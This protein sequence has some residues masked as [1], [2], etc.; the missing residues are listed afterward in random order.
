MGCRALQ[1]ALHGWEVLGGGE[2]S[3]P[4]ELDYT[5]RSHL[6]HFWAAEQLDNRDNGTLKTG[7]HG[8]ARGVA[9]AA[10]DMSSTSMVRVKAVQFIY[11]PGYTTDRIAFTTIRY[12][13]DWR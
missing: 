4:H 10:G 11:M 1:N 8:D 6:C 3:E 9:L 7:L 2:L 12:M 5:V 13:H